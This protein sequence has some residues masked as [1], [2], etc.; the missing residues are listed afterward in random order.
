MKR[1]KTRNTVK[2]V[3][4]VDEISSQIECIHTSPNDFTQ[5]ERYKP[6]KKGKNKRIL[7]QNANDE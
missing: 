3:F 7:Y 5:E 4:I 2:K 1:G 6:S